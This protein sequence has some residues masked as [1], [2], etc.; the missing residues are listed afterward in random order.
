M[1]LHSPV[2]LIERDDVPVEE[3]LAYVNRIHL[4]NG[5]WGAQAI[6]DR[7]GKD[8]ELQAFKDWCTP[9]FDNLGIAHVRWDFWCSIIPEG[10]VDKQNPG[11]AKNFPHNH[12]WNGTTLILYLQVPKAGGDLVI[13]EDGE[14][15]ERVFP[16]PGMAAT[17]GGWD[18]HGVEAVEGDV[19]RITLITTVFPQE[20][21][22]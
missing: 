7:L 9:I 4:G 12:C 21:R 15:L 20:D 2:Y 3:W 18:E 5:N 6:T 11:W 8:K 1:S 14:E 17:V 16:N 13:V 22:K 19:P 10:H